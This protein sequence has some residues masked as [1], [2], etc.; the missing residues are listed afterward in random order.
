M[1][2]FRFLRSVTLTKSFFYRN[3]NHLRWQTRRKTQQL[4]EAYKT[5][6]VYPLPIFLYFEEIDTL[7]VKIPQKKFCDLVTKK[8]VFFDVHHHLANEKIF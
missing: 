4:G 3:L 7:L 6:G 5:Y 8:V 1:L 2:K